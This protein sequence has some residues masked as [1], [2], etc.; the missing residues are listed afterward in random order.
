MTL[1]NSKY[2]IIKRDIHGWIL[3]SD[4]SACDPRIPVP[5]TAQED[6]R[7]KSELKQHGV[8]PNHCC[9]DCSFS[10]YSKT[11]CIKKKRAAIQPE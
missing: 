4:E 1:W 10:N 2:F 3:G 5:Q 7:S 6:E 8:H 11:N 9:H